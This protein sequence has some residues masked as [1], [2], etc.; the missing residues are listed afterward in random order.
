MSAARK[1]MIACGIGMVVFIVLQVI[2]AHP[3]GHALWHRLPFFSALY[4][5]A[6]CLVI[7]WASKKLGK[8][9]LQKPESYYGDE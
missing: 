9:W 7:V 3:H 6:G 5:V 8:L 4:G 2:F 1:W